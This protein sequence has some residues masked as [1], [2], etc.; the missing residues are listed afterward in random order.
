MACKWATPAS[1]LR[2]GLR[3]H[4]L[5]GTAA[6]PLPVGRLGMGLDMGH[7]IAHEEQR[8]PGLVYLRESNKGTE[9]LMST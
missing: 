1:Q 7:C 5:I 3:R 2:D 4:H 6:L 9:K 8:G